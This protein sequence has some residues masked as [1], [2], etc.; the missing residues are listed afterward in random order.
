VRDEACKVPRDVIRPLDLGASRHIAVF[1]EAIS[2]ASINLSLTH[3]EGYS[4]RRKSLYT[5]RKSASDST[6]LSV[7]STNFLI[8]FSSFLIAYNLEISWILSSV[9]KRECAVS[10]TFC[11]VARRLFH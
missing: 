10:D 3:C 8:N 9:V 6:V 11:T 2:V 7:A 4:T 5:E 1:E